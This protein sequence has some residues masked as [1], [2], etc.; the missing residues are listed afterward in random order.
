VRE[1]A[2]GLWGWSSP[3]PGWGPGRGWDRD[4]WAYFVDAGDANL[5]V[6]PI[7]PAE[8]DEASRLDALI[9]SPGKPVVILLSRAGHF[10]D[11]ASFAEEYGAAIYGESSAASRVPDGIAFH[12]VTAGDALP[13]GAHVLAYDVP[14]LDHAPLYLSSHRAIV[15][16]DILLRAEGELRVWWAPENEDDVRFLRERHLPALRRWLDAPVEHVLT[17]HGEPV[18]G[19]GA[20]ELAA[21]LVRPTWTVS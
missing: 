11:S 1:L 19:R 15:P 9:S 8:R 13:G 16:G 10:R 7:A 4:V 21:A 5:L 3:H 18:I 12:A 2:R 14:G 6:D 20:D 17:S